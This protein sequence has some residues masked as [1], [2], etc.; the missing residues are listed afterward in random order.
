M[1]VQQKENKENLVK[2]KLLYTALIL[3][4]YS[5]GK[6][7][8]LYGIDV[9]AYLHREVGAEDLLL[10]TIQGDVFKCSLF[11]L[12]ISPYMISSMLIQ[13]VSAFRKS[14]TRSKISPKKTQKQIL[15]MTLVVAIV[16]A[17]VQVQGLIFK[18][19]AQ[20]LFFAKSIAVVEMI[21]GAMIIVWLC[22]RNKKYGIGGQTAL[23][24]TNIVDGIHATLK[25][26]G[27]G[28]LLVPAM[29]ALIVMIVVIVMENTEFR[30]PVQRISIHNIYADKNYM[31]I[32]LN[33]IGVMPAMFS[34][35]AFMI[36]TLL[37]TA[38]TWIFPG[39][40]TLLWWQENM[41]LNNPLGIVVYILLIYTLSI[42]FSR[43]FI[44][45]K[46]MTEQYLKSGD[47]LLNIHAG[48]DTRKYLSRVITRISF[49]SATVMSVCLAIPMIL[50]LTGGMDSSLTALPSSVLMLTGVWCN[51]YREVLAVRDL[52]AY[53]PF[54]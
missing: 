17:V 31:A 51:L 26:H 25:G 34:S 2:Y 5:I 40:A 47:S 16:Q 6:G 7:L 27:I 42:G 45:P 4:V 3:L 36:P 52:E 24:F 29:I 37:I 54:I 44:N 39:N 35:A 49:A 9:S 21:T 33:P 20:E 23:I 13:I 50:Q 46:D 14:E 11:A 38:L 30:I 41:S 32:K 18:V 48:D 28:T 10:Q 22:S 53:K 43:V 12:G 8:P 19:S 1:N 15:G